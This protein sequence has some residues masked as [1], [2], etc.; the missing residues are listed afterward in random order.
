[1]ATDEKQGRFPDLPLVG[2][3]HRRH[4]QYNAD[5]SQAGSE[6][7]FK[8][9]APILCDRGEQ[10]LVLRTLG[11]THSEWLFNPIPAISR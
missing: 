8:R 9:H 2:H 10:E 1:V 6:S 3:H 5:R 4:R 7:C 11:T